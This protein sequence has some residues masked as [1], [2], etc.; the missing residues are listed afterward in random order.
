MTNQNDT[1][2]MLALAH[3]ANQRANVYTHWGRE[4]NDEPVKKGTAT[5]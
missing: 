2:A 4:R 1:L 3:L 5:Y